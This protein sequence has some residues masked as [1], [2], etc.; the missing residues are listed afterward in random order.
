MYV[1]DIRMDKKNIMFYYK[2]YSWS[3]IIVCTGLFLWQMLVAIPSGQFDLINYNKFGE[4]WIEM[5]LLGV[6]LP[7]MFMIWR[8]I[9]Y[10]LVLQKR[11]EWEW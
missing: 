1:G 3:A 6:A 10:V 8:D 2:L 9:L 4:L 7:G 11:G 5:G